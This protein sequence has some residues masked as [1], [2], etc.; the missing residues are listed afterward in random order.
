MKAKFIKAVD[1][2]NTLRV[3]LFLVNE[4]MLDPRGRSFNE[5]L[6]YAQTHLAGL[7]ESSDGKEYSQ[8]VEDWNKDFL[9]ELKNDLDTNFSKERI[10]FYAKVAKY[11]LR[12]KVEQLNKEEEEQKNKDKRRH[13]NVRSEHYSSSS[14]KKAYAGVTAGGV[15]LTVAGLCAQK[16]ILASLGVA[17]IVIG[18]VLLYKESQK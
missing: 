15:V 2:G 1:E 6:D 13:G 18:G 5:M 9:F 3:R 7:F 10:E 11:V 14:K 12:D 8:G 16:A 17:G 4:L